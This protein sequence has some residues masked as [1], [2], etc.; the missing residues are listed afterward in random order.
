MT[1]EKFADRGV[2]WTTSVIPDLTQTSIFTVNLTVRED[3]VQYVVCEYACNSLVARSKC[4]MAKL[5]LYSSSAHTLSA[6]M[7]RSQAETLHWSL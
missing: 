2:S 7:C 1:E 3:A 5:L 6:G 4:A